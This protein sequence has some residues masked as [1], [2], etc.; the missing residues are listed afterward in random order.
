M[1]RQSDV[2]IPR[3][4]NKAVK[5]TRLNPASE[6]T[7]RVPTSPTIVVVGSQVRA[8]PVARKLARV[9]ANT[10]AWWAG[11]SDA[12]LGFV[13]ICGEDAPFSW[14]LPHFHRPHSACCL[15][16]YRYTHLRITF[17]KDWYYGGHSYSKAQSRA[18]QDWYSWPPALV[19]SWP[20]TTVHM[21]CCNW[22]S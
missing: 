9:G 5:V 3:N 8:L 21:K 19:R 20:R 1:E 22:D 6:D 13:N 15:N 11:W 16:W 18:L 10:G 4:W 17:D 12:A 14:N 2:R 7:Y